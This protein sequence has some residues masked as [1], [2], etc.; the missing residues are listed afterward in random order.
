MLAIHGDDH[1]L[2]LPPKVAP[3]Q[4]V[5]VPIF[6]GENK[7]KILKKAKELKSK[8]K[9]YEVHLDDRDG[10]SPG[11]KFH[12]WELKGIPIRIEIG[13]KDIIKNQVVI[14]RRDI[15]KKE[16]VKISQLNKKVKSLLEEIQKNLFNR[17]EKNLK[18]NIVNIKTLDQLKTTI[19]KGKFGKANWCRTK[20]CE[21]DF[22]YKTNGA[23][24]LNMPFNEKAKGK[25]F[26]CSKQAKDIVYIGK[27]Y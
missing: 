10:Y 18:S 8:L 21:E 27:S 5:I 26:N 24:T 13:P 14:V 9:S 15:P 17:A 4:A 12:E 1:G 20:S 23:K 7:K 16:V 22:K 11:W 25:C 6:T 19:K 2:V 3:I